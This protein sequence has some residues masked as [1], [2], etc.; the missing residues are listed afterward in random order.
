ML[1][2]ALLNFR[3]LFHF[4]FPNFPFPISDFFAGCSPW[5]SVG[6]SF[7]SAVD[8]LILHNATALI[9]HGYAYKENRSHRHSTTT[10]TTAAFMVARFVRKVDFVVPILGV[11]D[12]NQCC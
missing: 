1:G 9:Q 11:L 4:L 3:F 2:V 7:C 5:T 6:Y 12:D 8:A 10:T